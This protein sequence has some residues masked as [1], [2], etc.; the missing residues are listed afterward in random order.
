MLM[1]LSDH[2]PIHSE[3]QFGSLKLITMTALVTCQNVSFFA[4]DT[5]EKDELGRW[6]KGHSRSSGS[7]DLTSGL[8]EASSKARAKHEPA[9]L[10]CGAAQVQTR[11]VG[12]EVIC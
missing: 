11:Q 5:P 3:R 9:R 6:V 4:A 8:Q 10:C 7:N 12:L 1:R 2:L